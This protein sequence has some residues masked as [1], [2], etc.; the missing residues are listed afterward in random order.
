MAW[1]SVVMLSRRTNPKVGMEVCKLISASAR[2]KHG[3]PRL[4]ERIYLTRTLHLY[5]RYVAELSPGPHSATSM[6][7]P[8][9]V[10]AIR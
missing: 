5:G 9:T 10:A 4:T 1:L 6:E 2:N 3:L 8:N 7:S